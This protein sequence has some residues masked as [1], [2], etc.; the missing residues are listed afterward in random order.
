M[1]RVPFLIVR[2]ANAPVPWI[3]DVRSSKYGFGSSFHG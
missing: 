3:F 2:V 1:M